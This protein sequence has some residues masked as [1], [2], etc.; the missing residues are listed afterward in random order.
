MI[1]LHKAHLNLFDIGAAR[2]HRYTLFCEINILCQLQG[3]LNVLGALDVYRD[4]EE[5]KIHPH[6]YLAPQYFD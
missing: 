4:L 1:L 3:M 5:T 2:N 6:H